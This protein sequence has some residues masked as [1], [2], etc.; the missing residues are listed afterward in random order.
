M[1]HPYHEAFWIVAG[2]AAPVIALAAVVAYG[3][4]ADVW[5]GED[6]ADPAAKQ[7]LTGASIALVLSFLTQGAVLGTA[8]LSLAAYRDKWGVPGVAFWLIGAG[9]FLLWIGALLTAMVRVGQRGAKSLR[10]PS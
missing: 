3:Q 1:A 9:I 5:P 7:V 10:P 6:D 2:T 4:L 8:L